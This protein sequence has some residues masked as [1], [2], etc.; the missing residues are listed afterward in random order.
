MSFLPGVLASNKA[1][2][3]LLVDPDDGESIM[4]LNNY[5]ET[6]NKLTGTLDAYLMDA[7]GLT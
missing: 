2:V 1:L 7:E 5:L 4:A 3:H 6:V